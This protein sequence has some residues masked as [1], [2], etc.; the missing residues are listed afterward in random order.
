VTELRGLLV[1]WGGVL[2]APLDGAM[3][4]W[5]RGDGIDVQVF[6]DVMHQWFEGPEQSP[7]EALERG[8]IAPADFEQSLAAAL[9][10]RGLTVA[11]EGLLT[12]ML[13]GLAVPA[14]DMLSLVRRARRAGIRT[15]LLS[16]SWGEH[17]DEQQWAGAFDAVVISGRL[18]L[19]KPDPAIF[20]HTADLLGLA[21]AACVM[22]DDLQ[23]NISGAVD[24]GMVGVLHR[25][26]AETLV[27]LEALFGAALA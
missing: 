8:L 21:A 18:G 6:H 23:L 20:R 22:V 9:A 27:E 16:N 5:A 13:G 12:R 26:Y 10:G 25:T 17:Y 24:A 2:T 7:V 19:R 11:S 4:E 3:A 15:A 14:D 1:D